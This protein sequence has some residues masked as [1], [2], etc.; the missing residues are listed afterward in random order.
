MNEDSNCISY[1]EKVLMKTLNVIM[2]IIY[3]TIT[4]R[5]SNEYE[6]LNLTFVTASVDQLRSTSSHFQ[7]L[8][9][10]VSI[11]YSWSMLDDLISLN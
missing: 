11:W 9:Y 6:F 2:Y 5:S 1:T 3:T 7:Y 8:Y 10:Y 4:G